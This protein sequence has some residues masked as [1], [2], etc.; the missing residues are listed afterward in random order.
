MAIYQSQ[1]EGNRPVSFP[2]TMAGSG[3]AALRAAGRFAERGDE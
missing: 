1:L 2:V 3:V